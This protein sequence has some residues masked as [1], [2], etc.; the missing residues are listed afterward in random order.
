MTEATKTTLQLFT[1]GA[2]LVAALAGLWNTCQFAQLAG[3]V[4][5]LETAHN[6]HV[7]SGQH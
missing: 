5:T 2:A 3:R 7:N 6:A 4:A 1:A